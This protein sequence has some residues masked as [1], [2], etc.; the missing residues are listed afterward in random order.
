MQKTI[1]GFNIISL[2]QG[3]DS[4]GRSYSISHRKLNSQQTEARRKR[5]GSM[6]NLIDTLDS[7][8]NLSGISQD[9]KKKCSSIKNLSCIA[10]KNKEE[11]KEV[12]ITSV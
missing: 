3:G 9:T 5:G 7:G 11:Q 12:K 2:F 6:D 8:E 10:P 1:N 4:S